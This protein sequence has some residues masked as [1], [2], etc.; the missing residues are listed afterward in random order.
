MI[1][2][3]KKIIPYLFLLIIVVGIGF[4]GKANNAQAGA[5]WY[6]EHSN[7]TGGSEINGP[8]ATEEECKNDSTL[9]GKVVR[10][11]FK[12]DTTPTL[13]PKEKIEAEIQKVNDKRSYEESISDCLLLTGG[14]DACAVKFTYYVF[15][16]VPG[17]I[18]NLVANIFNIVVALSLSSSMYIH[19][20]IG[21]SWAIVR[22]LSNIFF[23]FILLYVAIKM[24]LGMGGHDTKKMI[25]QVVVMAL[26]INFS[27][28][29]TKVVID[30][31]NVLALIFYNKINVQ[32]V[33]PDGTTSERLYVSAL[34]GG[35]GN[36]E[37]KDISGGLVGK[38][39]PTKLMSADFF[40]K[41][42]TRAQVAPTTLGLGASVATGAVLG[43]IIP[44]PGVGAGV[45]A[46][47]GAGVY[48]TGKVVAYYKSS[49]PPGIMIG[50]TLTAGFMMLFAAYAFFM[51]S[52]AFLSRLIELWVL[53]IFSPFAFMSSALPILGH[54][55][56]IGWDSWIK[57]LMK[58]AF[59]APIFMFFMY[60]IFKII[61][62]D[63]WKDLAVRKVAD[64]GMVEFMVFL[65]IPGL[66]ILVLL[67]QAAK[68]AKESSGKLG[69]A[70]LK[71]VKLAGGL[72]LGAA[73]AGTGLAVSAGM[74][75]LG[76]LV[77][78]SK[79]LNAAQKLNGGL[80][81]KDGWKGRGAR[82]A[83]GLADYSTKASFD[84]RN[85]PGFGAV[86]KMGGLN[87][88]SIKG[89]T[90]KDA[91]GGYAKRRAER[92]K[93]EQERANALEVREDEGMKQE[94]NKVEG[95]LQTLMR[96]NSAE[97]DEIDR[98][99]EAKTKASKTAAAAYG[100]DSLEARKAGMAV[101]NLRDRRSA[102]KNG[103]DYKGDK[104]V[105]LIKVKVKKKDR[106]GKEYEEE[107]DKL[108][109]IDTGNGAKN[110]SDQSKYKT[111]LGTYID[112]EGNVK[113]KGI[114]YHEDIAIPHAHHHIEGENRARKL[115]KAER[116][117]KGWFGL[118]KFNRADR[119]AAHKII[120]EAK[121]ED[122][123]GHH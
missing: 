117:Q 118:R 19:K 83:L 63:I 68:Y 91:Q 76:T 115:A 17:W 8:F 13:T 41:A 42:R 52:I 56:Y 108:E 89:V 88:D 61:N 57:K 51:A 107:Q 65:I 28:F 77:A 39:D 97:L 14:F 16:V 44:I 7:L 22:D 55:D 100:H 116:L 34:K 60:L 99:I 105:N 9:F 82:M 2:Q 69:E 58:T 70:M 40:E 110:Y 29:F 75:S 37:E 54:V 27:M 30:S 64:Q 59:M 23:I 87:L 86:A 18:L 85:I 101:Q 50:I 35:T 10:E 103:E 79:S 33:N 11:C 31:S 106:D 123:G 104:E 47:V 95:D 3:L 66:I 94:L 102:L 49:I 113:Q 1:R 112:D 98:L 46:I 6:W 26:L 15:Y 4:F 67:L 84:P 81:S 43:N 38:F 72:A 80:L 93:K 53:I 36:V 32:M 109:V 111:S 74:G 92:E 25:V 45:G 121:L 73:T 5:S 12:S 114:N 119:S 62:A 71:G 48:Y 78:S 20:F 120:M 122:K 24:I 90:S 21:D 96:A